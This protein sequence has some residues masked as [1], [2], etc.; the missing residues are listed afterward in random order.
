[1][2]NFKAMAASLLIAASTMTAMAESN[3]FLEPYTSKY[4]IPP[5]EQIKTSDFIPAIKAGIEQQ[6]QNLMNIL[7]NRAT[8]D[9][10]NTIV[11]LE[12]LSP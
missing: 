8:P 3:P 6:E 10:D 1:M 9:F 5:F 2:G 12:N 11:P 4:E 7:R